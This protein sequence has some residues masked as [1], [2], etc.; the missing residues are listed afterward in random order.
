VPSREK[1]SKAWL[2]GPAGH[3]LQSGLT[4]K[5][6]QLRRLPAI[7]RRMQRGFLC[8]PD[9]VAE[10]EGFA[11]RH[12]PQA[13]MN[14]A[15]QD[16]EKFT[17]LVKEFNELLDGKQASQESPKDR[18]LRASLLYVSAGFMGGL[19]A[20]RFEKKKILIH[21]VEAVEAKSALSFE[22]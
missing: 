2:P 12:L 18:V 14:A 13:P 22:N 9:C 17:A 3:F 10:R 7:F 4:A 6:A 8:N 1:R 20:F 11:Q 19:R 16:H 21:W 15:E 5:P